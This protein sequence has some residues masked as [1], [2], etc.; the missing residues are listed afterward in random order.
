MT[1]GAN[2]WTIFRRITLPPLVLPLT[3]GA[4]LG[5][6]RAIGEFGAVVIVAGN[7]PFYTQT[8]A[9]YVLGE[10]ESENRLGASAISIVMIAI[11]FLL[12]MLVNR[13]QKRNQQEPG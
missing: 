9:V 6:A 7:I 3:S 2:S 12:I 10:V 11:S 1:L 8:A 4:L 13:L 5:F